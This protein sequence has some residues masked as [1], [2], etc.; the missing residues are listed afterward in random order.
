MTRLA[1]AERIEKDRIVGENPEEQKGIGSPQ[2]SANLGIVIYPLVST[3]GLAFGVVLFIVG[4]IIWHF[5]QFRGIGDG[6]L[7]IAIFV[8]LL[9]ILRRVQHKVMAGEGKISRFIQEWLRRRAFDPQR[10]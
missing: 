9:N 8:F 7:A 1:P 4:A 10:Q 2:S 5:R 6:V 3:E